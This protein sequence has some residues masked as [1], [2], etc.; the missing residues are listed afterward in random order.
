VLTLEV[1]VMGADRLD[2]YVDERPRHSTDVVDGRRSIT[3]SGLASASTVR[4]DG[5]A[6]GALVSSRRLPV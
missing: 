6:G 3:V 1:E 2:V 4:I 5:F